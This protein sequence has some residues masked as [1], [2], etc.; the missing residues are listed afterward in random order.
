VKIKKSGTYAATNQIVID[1]EFG[2]FLSQKTSKTTTSITVNKKE[3]N[4]GK[5]NINIKGKLF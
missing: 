1:I 3:L 5:E 4:K 2:T